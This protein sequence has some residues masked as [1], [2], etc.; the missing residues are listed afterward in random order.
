MPSYNVHDAKTH[1]SK[2]LD[3][4]LQGQEVLIT[5]NGLPVAELVP[6][7]KRAFPLGLGRNDSHINREFLLADEWWRPISEEELAAFLEGRD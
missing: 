6:A 1:F 7:R 4:V 3:D 5:R 2:L